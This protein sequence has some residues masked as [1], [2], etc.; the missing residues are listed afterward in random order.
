MDAHTLEGHRPLL[1]N[2]GYRMT[3]SAA[4]ADDV[5]QEAFVR[6][7]ERP[8][9]WAGVD[10]PIRPWLVRVTMNV[11]RDV[12]R[13][14]KRRGYVGPWLPEP[15][16]VESVPGPSPD[17][18]EARYGAAE[19]SSYAFLL[20]LELLTPLQR[21]VLLLR[22]V[23]DFDLRE[24][25]AALGTSEGAVKAAHH[26]ARKA[27][28]SYDTTRQA[29]SAELVERSRGALARLASAL[30]VGDAA[31]VA[32]LLT[33]DVRTLNDAGGRYRAALKP[34]VG[35]NKVAR[36]YLALASRGLIYRGDTLLM[37]GLPALLLD[38]E[39]PPAREAPR[40]LIRVE[41]APDD[42]IREIHVVL[43]PKKLQ[44][45]KKLDEARVFP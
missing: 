18:P 21:A 27:L 29:P 44:R 25:A 35:R 5:V 7:L 37:N 14:R 10:A 3:G 17:W 4:D 12:L 16:D 19:S 36:F 26:R 15:V 24:T 34:V 1:W 13:R 31:A 22:D 45:L 41:L 2:L 40:F 23:I 11:A 20:A 43:A 30:A 6:A 42:R 33:E 38:I 28:E 8:P 32:A 9:E 39:N